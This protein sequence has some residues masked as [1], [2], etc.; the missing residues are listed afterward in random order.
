[1]ITVN[2]QE[3]MRSGKIDD[4]VSTW[5]SK[6]GGCLDGGRVELIRKYVRDLREE[7]NEG[8]SD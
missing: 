2:I 5:D 7:K 1:M 6:G 4:S 3:R 8:K